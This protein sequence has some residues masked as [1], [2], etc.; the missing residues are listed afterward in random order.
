MNSED[1]KKRTNGDGSVYY[2]K[3][4]DRWCASLSLDS[5]TGKPRRVTRTVPKIGT[6]KHQEKAAEALLTKLR[7]ERDNNGDIP[8]A[9]LNVETWARRWL[10]EIAV[11]E[12]RP[13]TASTYRTD[14]EQYIIPA[15]GRRQLRKLTPDHVRQV[16]EFIAAKGLTRSR[17]RAYQTL[18]QILESARREGHVTRNVADLVNRPRTAKAKLT[19]LTVEHALKILAATTGRP[20]PIAIDRLASR[21]WAALFTGARQGELLGLEW[22]RV[23][24]ERGVLDL[25]W[26]L[27]RL[28]WEHGCGAPIGTETVKGKNGKPDRTIDIYRCGRKRGTDCTQRKLTSPADWENRHIIGGLWWSR[29]KSSAGWRIIP[30]VSPLREML[31][32]RLRESVTEP[33]PHGL[34]WTQPNGRPVDPSAD[35]RAWHEVL[36][37]AG[38]PDARLHDARHATASLLRKAGVPIGTIVRIMGHSTQAMSEAYIDYEIDTLHDGMTRMSALLLESP[39]KGN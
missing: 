37:L 16:D 30:L 32:L 6:P 2:R 24:F 17:S 14:I 7:R 36:A 22:D 25:S 23:D 19:M 9:I 35:N 12:V 11:K 8:T 27:Q 34:V 18:S 21:W 1:K 15:I 3:S 26:Q 4:D 5:D 29:P 13:G 39:G 10:N 28:S 38:V 31:E 20:A 33:N